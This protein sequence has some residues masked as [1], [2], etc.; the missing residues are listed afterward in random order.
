MKKG[1]VYAIIAYLIW[2]LFPIYF[3]YLHAVPSLQV[4]AHRLLWSFLLLAIL[5]IVRGEWPRL[6]PAVRNPKWLLMFLVAAL[7]LSVNWLT[8]VYGVS[9]GMIV[10]TSLGY[11]INPLVS[12]LLGVIFL[13]ERLR[14]MQWVPVGL[15]TLGV[16][17][18]TIDYGRLPWI[19]LLLAASF[20]LYG[21][22]KKT[23]PLGSFYSLT[24]E[25]GVLFIPSLIFLLGAAFAGTGAFG[26][27]G[28]TTTLLLLFTGP[29]TIAPLL[30]FGSAARQMDLSMMGLLQYITPTMQF[31]IG[32]LVYREPFTTSSLIGFAI[33]WTA[34]ILFWVEGFYQ[35]QSLNRRLAKPLA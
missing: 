10:E 31:L 18:L 33:I 28:L 16:I 32:V 2:G 30:L 27:A 6:R 35:R 26:Q 22:A 3:T 13:R 21:L 14:P 23:A 8:Y 29:I 11:F 25:T 20:G 5:V 34:L 9:I 17:Y 24:M 7:L 1:V 4:V 15:A 19:A 12:V